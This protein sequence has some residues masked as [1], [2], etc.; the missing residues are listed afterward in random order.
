MKTLQDTRVF[1]E[2]QANDAIELRKNHAIMLQS[3]PK[4]HRQLFS[5]QYPLLPK[6]LSCPIYNFTTEVLFKSWVNAVFALNK[7]ICSF[8]DYAFIV[9]IR[10]K[11]ILNSD[12]Y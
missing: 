1:S 12:A 9:F 11:H 10:R 8:G 3:V 5:A 6:T 4:E 7:Q 2:Q